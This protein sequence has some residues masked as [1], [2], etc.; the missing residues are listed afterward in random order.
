MT[1]FQGL[2]SAWVANYSATVTWASQPNTCQNTQPLEAARPGQGGQQR[3]RQRGHFQVKISTKVYPS[4][5]QVWS[6]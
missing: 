6:Q 3:G 2:T 4:V 5:A 1:L